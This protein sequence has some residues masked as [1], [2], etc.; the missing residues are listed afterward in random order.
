MSRTYVD[1]SACDT[2]ESERD[3]YRDADQHD[4]RPTLREVEAEER[5]R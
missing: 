1:T 2:H 3:A 4:D 5:D